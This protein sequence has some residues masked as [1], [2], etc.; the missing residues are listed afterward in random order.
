MREDED[1]A[2]NLNLYCGARGGGGGWGGDYLESINTRGDSKLG[3]RGYGSLQSKHCSVWQRGE[4]A[5]CQVQGRHRPTSVHRSSADLYMIGA[6]VKR[7]SINQMGL[8]ANPRPPP[9]A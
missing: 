3:A 4:T 8:T 6:M 1:S 7:Y 9:L 2:G 5:Q